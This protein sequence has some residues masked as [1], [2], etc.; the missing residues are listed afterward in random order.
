[1]VIRKSRQTN[2]LNELNQIEV[3]REKIDRVTK[4]KYLSL[5][6]DES[7]SLKDQYEKIQ[8]SG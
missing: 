1:M 5:H 7:L 2:S 8:S 4:T 6:I 3:N